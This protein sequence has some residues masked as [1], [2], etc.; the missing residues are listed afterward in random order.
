MC[1]SPV[2]R[3]AATLAQ[4]SALN[5]PG[6]YAPFAFYRPDGD[7]RRTFSRVRAIAVAGMVRSLAGRMARQTGHCEPPPLGMAAGRIRGV[8]EESTPQ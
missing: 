8:H 2:D 4:P 6:S 1:L 3:H 7:T 5:A